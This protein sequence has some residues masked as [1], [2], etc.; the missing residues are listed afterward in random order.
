M[1]TKFFSREG[2]RRAYSW[3]GKPGK[4][5]VR[6]VMEASGWLATSRR[7]GYGGVGE[8]EAQHAR[9]RDKQSLTLLVVSFSCSF[10]HFPFSPFYSSL[11]GFLSPCFEMISP[12]LQSLRFPKKK[13][14]ELGG[15][16]LCCHGIQV[17]A[18]IRQVL[19]LSGGPP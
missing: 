9:S 6:S 2:R 11:I 3:V 14:K 16:T 17:I 12:Q 1:E 13:L 5:V 4:T 19:S 15:V 10:V 18:H 8:R 7:D